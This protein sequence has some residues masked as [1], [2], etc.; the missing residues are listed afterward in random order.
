MRRSLYTIP[1][2][3]ISSTPTVGQS[4]SNIWSHLSAWLR[5]E[6][7]MLGICGKT[8]ASYIGRRIRL[9]MQRMNRL[10][11]RHRR[12]WTRRRNRGGGRYQP[13]ST[14]SSSLRRNRYSIY[15]VSVFHRHLPLPYIYLYS[16]Y[17]GGVSYEQICFVFWAPL[18]I[19]GLIR[20]R[21]DSR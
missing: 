3:T 7:R 15:I 9:E 11:T 8:Q 14:L 1:G 4:S 21:P 6:M 19:R 5:L 2:F 20:A 18:I 17:R 13:R 10:C 12:R 16:I